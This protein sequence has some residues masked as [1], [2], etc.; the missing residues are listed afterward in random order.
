MAVGATFNDVN[1]SSSVYVH[2]YEY[3]VTSW[4]KVGN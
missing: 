1:G 3:I 4:V 2:V